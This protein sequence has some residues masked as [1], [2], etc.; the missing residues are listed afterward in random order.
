MDANI[1]VKQAIL[2]MAVGQIEDQASI[3]L[4]GHALLVHLAPTL[5]SKLLG[6][7]ELSA[8][9]TNARGKEE[10]GGTTNLRQGPSNGQF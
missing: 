5:V 7:S 2:L 1:A 9:V 10:S 8:S 6:A 3:F 4:R